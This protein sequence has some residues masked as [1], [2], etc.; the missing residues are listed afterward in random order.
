MSATELNAALRPPYQG[1]C[2]ELDHASISTSPESLSR[3]EIRVLRAYFALPADARNV[4]FFE[5]WPWCLPLQ[6]LLNRALGGAHEID[7]S[8]ASGPL[9]GSS[10]RAHTSEKYFLLGAAYERHNWEMLMQLAQPGDVVY[11]VGAHAGYWA[12]GLARMVGAKGQV[13]ALEPSPSNFARLSHNVSLNQ[14]SGRATSIL[15]LNLA[16]GDREGSMMMTEAG[17]M[18]RLCGDGQAIKGAPAAKVSVRRLDDLVF[19]DGHAVP[20][21][22]LIDVEGAAGGVLRGAERL[23]HGRRQTFFA[24]YTALRKIER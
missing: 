18:S 19:M 16:A 23:L 2:V 9:A 4:L 24:K 15:A 8:F 10:F 22:L 14:S 17:T 12:L 21:L 11:E 1:Q 5:S 7:V 13:I 3:R 20:S 6:S